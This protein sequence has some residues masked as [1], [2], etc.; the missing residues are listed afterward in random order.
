[1]IKALAF[2]KVSKNC[3]ELMLIHIFQ[4][5]DVANTIQKILERLIHSTLLVMVIPNTGIPKITSNCLEIWLILWFYVY[6]LTVWNMIEN[7]YLIDFRICIKRDPLN[8]CQIR[9]DR[10][11]DLDAFSTSIGKYLNWFTKAQCM[12]TLFYIN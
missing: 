4:I 1:M 3:S 7:D 10:N 2:W 11:P 6:N 8:D 12:F 5:K 9:M